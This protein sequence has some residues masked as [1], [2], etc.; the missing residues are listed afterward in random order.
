MRVTLRTL[1][2]IQ[3]EAAIET[4]IPTQGLLSEPPRRRGSLSWLQRNLD[5]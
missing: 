1:R 4:Y 5:G 2:I 3:R